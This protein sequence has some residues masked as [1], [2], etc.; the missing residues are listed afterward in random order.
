VLFDAVCE[1]GLEES[2]PS[3]G[4]GCTGPPTGAGVKTKNPNYW[5]RESDLAAVTR[6]VQRRAVA[7]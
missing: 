3:D 1:H 6:S 2:S 4:T 5:R 7:A